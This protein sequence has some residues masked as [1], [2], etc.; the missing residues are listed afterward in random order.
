MIAVVTGGS[1]FVGS[2]LCE[3]LLRKKNLVYCIDNL[4]NSTIENIH[5]LK[6]DKNFHFSKVDVGNKNLLIRSLPKEVDVIFHSAVEYKNPKLMKRTN[7]GGME[8]ILEFSR[9]ADVKKIIYISTTRVFGLHFKDEIVN[10]ESTCNPDSL[11]AK[12]KLTAENLLSDY[13]KS[14]DISYCILRPPRIYG[15]KDWQK[16][17]LNYSKMVKKTRFIIK[18]NLP[19]NLIYV[20]NLIH[21]IFL[22]LKSNKNEVYIITDGAYTISEISEAI[23]NSLY[24]KFTIPI[25][26]PSKLFKVYSYF[27]NSFTHATRRIIYSCKKIK[28]ELRYEPIYSLEDGIRRTLNF[29][30]FNLR[31]KFKV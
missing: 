12:T 11:Y 29:F 15:E 3:E 30:N 5:H 7:I 9:K 22:T 24:I 4:S 10:E 26:F 8:N 19:I 23:R 6:D 2:H 13:C 27:T 18:S 20:K 16:T 21:G 14:Y 1:G 31:T 25:S 28:E 17:F